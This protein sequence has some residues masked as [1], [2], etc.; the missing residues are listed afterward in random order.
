LGLFTEPFGGSKNTLLLETASLDKASTDEELT[1]G[2]RSLL[3]GKELDEA[4][5]TLEDE[6]KTLDDEFFA[7]EDE[8]FL[9]ED[10]FCRLE[11]DS[12]TLDERASR[13]ELLLEETFF[14]DDE[15]SAID[16]V[17]LESGSCTEEL[18]SSTFSAISGI[19]GES[20][21]P[22]EQI[23]K[24][25]GSKQKKTFFICSNIE[26]STFAN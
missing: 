20:E 10:D 19:D 6:R 25:S 23:K 11:D 3:V 12:E 4:A 13:T 17:P 16:E 8:T 21:S 15:D 24:Q 18:L 5:R 14:F 7:L 26:F 2:E 9:L 1:S 22:Q